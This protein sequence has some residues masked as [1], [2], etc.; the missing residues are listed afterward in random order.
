MSDEPAVLR[1]DSSDPLF[2][3]EGMFHKKFPSD[4]RQVRYF[5]LLI[6]QKAPPEIKEVNLL[7]QQVCE[8]LRNAIKH[9]N[10]G[11]KEKPVEVWYAFGSDRAHIIV[12]DEGEGFQDLERWNE[13]HRKRAECLRNEDYLELAN[14]VSYRTEDSDE[15]DGGNALFAAL[16]YWDAGMVFSD[17]RNAVAAARHFSSKRFG[18]PL[19]EIAETAQ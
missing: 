3:R 5:A 8:L 7:E 17:E 19:A 13:F 16:E 4:Y 18:V 14:Y 15:E 2:D 1:A 10:K 6:I 12:Q 11:D 9:G